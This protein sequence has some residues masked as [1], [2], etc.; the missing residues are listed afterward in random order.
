MTVDVEDWYQ[1]IENIPFEDWPNF[2]SRITNSVNRLLDIFKD[3]KV[4]ATFFILGYEAQRHPQ[5]VKRIFEAG[6]E[7]AS[8]GYS[9][10]LIYKMNPEDFRNELRLSINT[11]E[12]ITGEKVIGHRAPA[13]SI[14]RDSLW[15]LDTILK[16]GLL[17]DSSISPWKNYLFGL[18]SAPRFP[19]P[20]KKIDEKV[21]IEFPM[22]TIRLLHT[23]FPFVGG[24]FTRLLPYRAIKFFIKK[25]NNVGKPVLIWMHPWDLDVRQPRV[26]LSPILRRHYFNLK[27]SEKKLKQLLNDFSFSPVRATLKNYV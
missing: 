21:L 18:P 1:A 19:Y 27:S 12:S 11:L 16:E 17:Y 14:T 4:K 23:N 25:I 8:H 2:E 5:M 15:A 22:T 10:R 20:I 3:F 26:K 9:H 7:I 13:W 24:F 6:H